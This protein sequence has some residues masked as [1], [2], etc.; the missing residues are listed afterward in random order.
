MP[1]KSNSRVFSDVR[2]GESTLLFIQFYE[3]TGLDGSNP[4]QNRQ[5][6]LFAESLLLRLRDFDFD[7]GHL[8]RHLLFDSGC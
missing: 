3:K 5:S 2:A 4:A 6:L 8:A 7:A 1:T